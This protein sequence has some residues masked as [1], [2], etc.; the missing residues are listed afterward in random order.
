MDSGETNQLDQWGSTPQFPSTHWADVH[1]AAQGAGEQASVALGALLKRYEPVLLAYLGQKFGAADHQARDWFQSFISEQVMRREILREVRRI[2]GR[3]FRGFLLRSLSRFVISEIR[4]EQA[5]KRNPASGFIRLDPG[6]EPELAGAS[7][8][9]QTMFELNWAK[10]VIEQALEQMR[11]Q[12]QQA[13]R[14]EVWLIFDARVRAP[15]LE[16]AA[17]VPYDQLVRQLKIDSPTRA[18]NLLVTAKR[19]CLRCLREVVGEYTSS[20]PEL[21]AEMSALQYV[22]AN[23]SGG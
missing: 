22:L 19:I 12:C 15:L 20:P 18:Q 14:E 16:G 10:R 13:G 2:E 7:D 23:H 6:L 11:Q 1:L 3:H 21:E 5:L 17:V 9:A 4:R 8:P